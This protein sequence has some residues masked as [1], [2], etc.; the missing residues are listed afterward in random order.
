MGFPKILAHLLLS[1]TCLVYLW[2]YFDGGYLFIIDSGLIP[3]VVFS[4]SFLIMNLFYKKKKAFGIGDM[5]VI[6]AVAMTLTWSQ[7]IMFVFSSVI[8]AATYGVIYAIINKR[9]LKFHI[10]FVIFLT[11]GFVVC[12]I[13]ALPSYIC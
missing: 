2:R 13:F 9:D 3:G 6:L 1:F 12:L 10:P 5:F 4:I 8:L 7:S 11:I